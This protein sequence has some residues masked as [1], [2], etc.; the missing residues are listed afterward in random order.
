M[1]YAST[2]P[3]ICEPNKSRDEHRNSCRASDPKRKDVHLPYCALDPKSAS[4][5][6]KASRKLSH[7][8]TPKIQ[9]L[10]IKFSQYSSVFSMD[11]NEEPGSRG[12]CFC[13]RQF[14]LASSPNLGIS[15]DG[16]FESHREATIL[17]FIFVSH[18]AQN[19]FM[20]SGKP[21]IVLQSAHAITNGNTL[22]R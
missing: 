14:G 9:S 3:R 21:E 7:P 12:L 2:T 1:K 15:Q 13:A 11:E 16:E 17:I 5:R 6:K 19:E 20:A 4:I 18:F 8:D 22:T 10:S